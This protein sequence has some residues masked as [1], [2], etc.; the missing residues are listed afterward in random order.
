M[1]G[2]WEDLVPSLELCRRAWSLRESRIRDRPFKNLLNIGRKD[3]GGER[4]V[5]QGP[6][7]ADPLTVQNMKC[8]RRKEQVTLQVTDGLSFPL[9]LQG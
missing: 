6:P 8:Q 3:P 2:F 4:R 5:A 9:M 7:I 1:F